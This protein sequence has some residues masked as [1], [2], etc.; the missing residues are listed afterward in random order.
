MKRLLTLLIISLVLF[1]CDED[2]NPLETVLNSDVTAKESIA[3][4]LEKA[5]EDFASDA[6]LAGIYGLNVNLDGEVSLLD[7]TESIFVYIVQSDSKQQNKL[8]IPVY[9][10][11]PIESPIDFE[12]MLNL[13]NDAEAKGKI[14]EALGTLS[15][16]SITDINRFD[17][18]PTAVT[19]AL[20]WNGSAG[21]AFYNN[22][23]ARI[24]LFLMPS[25]SIDLT[26]GIVNSADWIVNF[27]SS[28][29]SLVLWINSGTGIITEF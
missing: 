1:S 24:D 17:D 10:A 20:G 2:D 21:S 15:G 26:E 4:V 9:G 12:T 3:Q 27:Y 19:Q 23:D 8:Y 29:E 11:G 5:R 13:V 16:V 18:S 25:K 14:E 28:N 22:N 7:P 6:Q